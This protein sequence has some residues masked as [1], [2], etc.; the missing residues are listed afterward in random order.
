VFVFLLARLAV[1][2]LLRA[3]AAQFCVPA[4]RSV[5]TPPSLYRHYCFIGYPKKRAAI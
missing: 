3:P 4:G 2:P 1:L 5:T